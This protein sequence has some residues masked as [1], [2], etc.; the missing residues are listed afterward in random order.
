MSFVGCHLCAHDHLLP[1]RIEEYNNIVEN[2]EYSDKDVP[3][4]LYHDYIFWMGDLNFRLI[5]NTF[6]A[7]EIE[8]KVANGEFAALLAKDQ[9]THVKR[10]GEAFSELT[11]KLPNFAPTYKFEVGTDRYNKK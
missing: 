5:E 7:D 9:L 6:D 8:T 11:E 2:H 1:N 10:E 4:I 3:K